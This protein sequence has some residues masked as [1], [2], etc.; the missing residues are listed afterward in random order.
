MTRQ[1][2]K[3]ILC[4]LQEREKRDRRDGRRDEKRWTGKTEEQE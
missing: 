1:P 2:L 3:V 4:H